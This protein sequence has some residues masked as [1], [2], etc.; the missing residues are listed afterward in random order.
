[1]GISRDVEARLNRH[2]F[3][4]RSESETELRAL[5]QDWRQQNGEDFDFKILAALA[6][7]EID[8]DPS[9]ELVRLLAFWVEKQKAA[10][11]AG[12]TPV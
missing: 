4:L 2:R 10:E 8:Q 6:P 11:P 9:E 1:M 7:D 12:Y 5:Q 3:A